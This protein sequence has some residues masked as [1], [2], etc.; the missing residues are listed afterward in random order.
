MTGG[1]R[2]G[3]YVGAAAPFAAARPA[4]PR[5]LPHTPPVALRT[6][7]LV[8]ALVAAL[9][10][11]CAAPL[12]AQEAAA[13]SPAARGV[14][15]GVVRAG[16]SGQPVPDVLVDVIDDGADAAP[17]AP[18]A[19]TDADGR[20]RLR[21]VGVGAR[22]LRFRHLGFRQLQL[23]AAVAAGDSLALDAVLERAPVPLARMV[24]SPG[25]Y[26]V[27][28][29]GPAT[30]Q[31]LTR[32]QIAAAPQVGE[33]IFRIASRLPGVAAS[34]FSAA[35]RVR[36]GAQEELLVT[37]DGVELYEPFHLK[38]FDGALS[39]VDLG[40]VG[41]L[42]LNTGGFGARWGNRLTGVMAMR[43]VTPEPGP[44]QGEAALTLTTL[45]GTARGTFADGR[46]G[47]LWSARRGFLEYA[48]RLSGDARDVRPVY[49]DAFG[50]LSFQP[51]PDHDVALH[52]LHAHDRLRYDGAAA[53]EPG[54][55]SVY[56]S[57]YLWLTWR[58]R[59]AERLTASTV[60]ST[61]SL[62]WRR[63]GDRVLALDG[64]LD[65]RIRDRRAFGAVALRQDWTLE[66]G[67]RAVLTWGVEGR[68]LDADYDYLRLRRVPVRQGQGIAFQVQRLEAAFG[69]TGSALGGYLSQRVRVGDALTLE[70]GVRADRQ[71]QRHAGA[72]AGAGDG[73]GD[74]AGVAEWH[75]GPRLAAAWSPG[76]H[77]T[78]RAAWGR[79]W[80]AQGVHELHVQ[81]GETRFE[82][83]ELAEHRVAG[84]ERTFGGGVEARLE[85][86]ERRTLRARPRWYSVDNT[87]DIL[88]EIGPN[89]QRVA[90]TDGVARGVELLLRRERATGVSW[91]ASYALA[92]AEDRVEGR[93]MPRPLDQRHTLDL[94]GAW[95]P[96]RAWTIGAAL[97]A[98]GGWPT[99]DFTVTAD[100]LRG[101]VILVE[102][103]Y[104]P[105]NAARLPAYV[106]L[107]ARVT[108]R[109]DAGGGR[110]ALFVDVFNALDR[111]LPRQPGIPAD[112]IGGLGRLDDRFDALLPR[113][114]SFGVTFEF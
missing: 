108:R 31:T 75:V 32:E 37:L 65:I 18:R 53:A 78:L 90:P 114:P 50:K 106:R 100:T 76:G 40:A 51:T 15:H 13:T 83:G 105:R 67:D 47:W 84:V 107:D 27:L 64:D 48:L 17:D 34:D 81:D 58:A 71:R 46:G 1:R 87:L 82:P 57:R 63:D 89:R 86:Y 28:R 7:T 12:R 11:P 113:V 66:L 33:D 93:W 70:G 52:L 60:V 72:G 39:I 99:T 56:G 102:R 42:D 21:D 92:R 61:T 44:P 43:S 101:G 112:A 10:A 16:D 41:G 24:V 2:R 80:Q 77:T 104:G 54:V 6:A 88:P 19:R 103:A 26:G 55:A 62:D 8:A 59:L 4:A 20:Y 14:V 69:A 29:D 111:R 97:V 110:L 45:R 36:G 38:D 95:R 91:S 96:S 68:D 98:H 5:L 74:G 49:H 22:T 30:V 25:Q 109:F 73:A 94:D 9:H 23:P 35:F 79:H 3:W 85:A